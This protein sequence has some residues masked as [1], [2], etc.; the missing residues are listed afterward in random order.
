MDRKIFP[1]EPKNE[2]PKTPSGRSNFKSAR[3]PMEF[4]GSTPASACVSFKELFNNHIT[5]LC[6]NIS[7]EQKIELWSNVSVTMLNEPSDRLEEII[8][9]YLHF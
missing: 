5:T 7:D 8:K 1:Q 2:T 6:S 4:H 9:N 3:K